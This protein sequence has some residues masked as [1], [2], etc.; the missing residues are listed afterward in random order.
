MSYYT[1]AQIVQNTR[2][3]TKL[4]WGFFLL[5]KNNRSN[6]MKRINIDFPA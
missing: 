2:P 4:L 6:K 5:Y 3:Q 1:G